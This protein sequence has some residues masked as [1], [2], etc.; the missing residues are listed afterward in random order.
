MV[1][2][3]KRMTISAF[4]LLPEWEKTQLMAWER[5]RVEKLVTVQE[6]LIENEKMSAAEHVAIQLALWG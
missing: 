6:S 3:H 1:V 4:M 5:E 2:R